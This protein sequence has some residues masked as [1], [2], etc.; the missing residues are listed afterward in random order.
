MYPSERRSPSLIASGINNFIVSYQG[1]QIQPEPN[2][3]WV[4]SIFIQ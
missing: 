2:C 1:L 4:M 3:I